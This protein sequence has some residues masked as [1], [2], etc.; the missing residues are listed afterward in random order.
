LV[1]FTFVQSKADYSL[2]TNQVQDKFPIVLVY[3]DDMVIAEND[4]QAILKL[5][6]LLSSQF[7]MKD[8]GEL[9]YFLGLEIVRIAQAL[10]VSQKKY[11]MD[12]IQECGLGHSK[13]IRVPL[14]TPVKL[15]VES[16]TILQEPDKYS[17]LVGK[18]LYLTLTKPDVSY[19][20]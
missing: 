15:N 10:F 1:S 7:H 17:K 16:G 4:K 11:V 20:V 6:Q 2:F 8:L 14:N 18:L 12:L 5:K 9:R 19:P 13:S 3:V